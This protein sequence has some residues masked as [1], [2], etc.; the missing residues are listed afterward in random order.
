[1]SISV[2]MSVY[3]SEKADYL[4]RSLRSIWTDQT[5]KPD[6]IVLVEDG[7]LGDELLDVINRWQ[8]NLGE[9]LII[10]VNDENLGLTK[11]LNKAIK[12]AHGDYL[13][14]MDSD[15]ISVPTRFEKQKN[16]LDR[17]ADVSVVGGML[18]EFDSSH[19]DLG[20]KH[21]P[22]NPES[23]KSYIYKGSPLAHPTVMMRSSLFQKG[24]AYNEKYRTSQ[25][26]ALWFDVLIAGY[27]ISNLDQ[28]TLYF[29]RDDE[30]MKRRSRKKAKNE[31]KIYMNGIYRLHGLFTWRYIYPLARFC[32]RMMPVSVVS[33]VYDSGIRNKVVGF[34]SHK[35]QMK[36]L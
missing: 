31:F 36:P 34:E 4:D 21:F 24:L 10:V 6:E 16:F 26:I 35:S 20:L 9:K 30:V 33:H 32:F 19:N 17:H 3:K 15:D 27:K 23:V 29:R 7:P 1:M 14:R 13:A 5:L 2:I 25:D 8:T 28:V 18:Q 22:V 12:A 11:S